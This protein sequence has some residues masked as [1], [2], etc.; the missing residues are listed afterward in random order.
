MALPFGN[1]PPFKKGG[2]KLY[3][4]DTERETVSGFKPVNENFLLNASSASTLRLP[5]GNA[6]TSCLQHR[7]RWVGKLHPKEDEG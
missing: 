3:F 2:R 7:I 1:P 5:I 4:Q 6:P